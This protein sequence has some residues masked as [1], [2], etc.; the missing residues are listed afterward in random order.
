MPKEL[1]KE[2]SLPRLRLCSPAEASSG[3]KALR[4]ARRESEQ[5]GPEDRGSSERRASRAVWRNEAGVR[6]VCA[7]R[8][9]VCWKTTAAR[10]GDRAGGTTHIPKVGGDM[11][12]VSA[13]TRRMMMSRMSSDPLPAQTCAHFPSSSLISLGERRIQLDTDN[14]RMPRCVQKDLIHR[15]AVHLGDV[16]AKVNLDEPTI[17]QTAQWRTKIKRNMKPG[18]DQDKSGH[19]SRSRAR[20]MPL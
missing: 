2:A 18:S 6:V 13:S 4:R 5:N 8:R 15:E 1:A 3:F 16:P 11:M 17:S 12:H 19:C 7:P 14:K 20:P 9:A 10:R